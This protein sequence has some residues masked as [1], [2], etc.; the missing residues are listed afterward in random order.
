MRTYLVVGALA[1]TLFGTT[2]GESILRWHVCNEI[3]KKQS[4]YANSCW[5]SE[6]GGNLD[7]V[8]MCIAD[9]SNQLDEFLD[10]FCHAL[11]NA[12]CFPIVMYNGA[13]KGDQSRSYI[14]S[15]TLK[16]NNKKHP[17]LIGRWCKGSEAQFVAMVPYKYQAWMFPPLWNQI[18]DN[19]LKWNDFTVYM[20]LAMGQEAIKPLESQKSLRDSLISHEEV[21]DND[22]NDEDYHP[23]VTAV[24]H[25]EGA[26]EKEEEEERDDEYNA[27]LYQEVTC[28]EDNDT[29]LNGNISTEKDVLVIPL[30][31]DVL[32]GNLDI[33][34]DE[35]CVGVPQLD[36]SGDST[37]LIGKEPSNRGIH[38]L[39]TENGVFILEN[40][41]SIKRS[42]EEKEVQ[43]KKK[44]K[45]N[46]AE[47]V[48]LSPQEFLENL[49]NQLIPEDTMKK[50]FDF[51]YDLNLEK[52]STIA[53]LQDLNSQSTT[54]GAKVMETNIVFGWYLKRYKTSNKL[55]GEAWETFLAKNHL[56]QR[57]QAGKYIQ[58]SQ[59]A[60]F[61]RFYRAQC[62]IEKLVEYVDSI[63]SYLNGND[64]ERKFWSEK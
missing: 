11:S 30:F 17:L 40:P 22:E 16:D 8:I 47:K 14:P 50:D 1:V 13:S 53:K 18:N 56:I 63:V 43:S 45:S 55:S 25:D 48:R 28:S 24:D 42:R 12:I 5:V 51:N 19:E 37:N 6:Q 4:Q 38:N 27:S 21:E 26:E 62:S 23:S 54:L 36:P 20:H 61:P 58:L 41:D 44:V 7:D 35:V 3:L 46:L 60:E 52:E 34:K 33:E 15:D 2:K 49:K 29:F 9:S 57:K 39:V 59:L 10:L 31:D 64:G 32:R